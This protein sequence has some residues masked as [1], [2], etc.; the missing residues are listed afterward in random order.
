MTNKNINN[1]GHN[2]VNLELPSGT[3]W[4][5]ANVGA[6]EPTDFGFYFQWGDTVGY[7]KE[8]VGTDEGKKYFGWDSYK[9]D[10]NK[11]KYATKG[12][13]LKPEDDAAHIHMGGDWHIPSPKQIDELIDNTTSEW[14]TQDGVNGML[15]TSKTDTSKS[16]FIPA[17]GYAWNGSVKLVGNEAD[18]WSSVLSASDVLDGQYLY[19]G[20]VGANLSDYDRSGG[21]SVR[22]V[23]G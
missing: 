15:F 4:A 13:T 3:L 2:F 8:Q 9:W 1:N 19:F 21:F 6:S 11:G 5:T 10:I 20:S 16:I 14:T 22:G 23:I 18:V 7:T 17:A 12:T